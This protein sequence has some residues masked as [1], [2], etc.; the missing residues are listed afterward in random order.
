MRIVNALRGV[1][2]DIPAL[3]QLHD[4]DLNM[5]HNPASRCPV[6]T[7][8]RLWEVAVL[9][10]GNEALGLAAAGVFNPAELDVLDYAMMFSPTLGTAL[11]RVSRYARIV[12]DATEYGCTPHADGCCVTFDFY[13][14]ERPPPRQSFEFAILSSLNF[15]RWMVGRELTPLQVRLTHPLPSRLQPYHDT[16]RCPIEFG[17]DKNSVLLSHADLAAPLLTYNA[18]LAKLHGRNTDE[19]NAGFRHSETSAKARAQIVLSL[20]GGKPSRD[21]VARALCMSERTL[22]RRLQNEGTSYQK[23][24]EDTRRDLT[25]QY[26]ASGAISL[27]EASYLLGFSD[28]S[29]FSRAAKRWF[30]LPPGE[31]RNRLAQSLSARSNSLQY[32]F[33]PNKLSE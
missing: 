6:D 19:Q 11:E 16:F 8:R 30:E 9:A 26:L 13:V 7:V 29:N 21:R 23:L 32:P 12:D 27:A 1:G 28:Q 22:H 25:A 10:S 18:Q 2:I 20:P 33:M 31:I 24:L 4:I 14:G 15:C 17:A 3:C 5:L